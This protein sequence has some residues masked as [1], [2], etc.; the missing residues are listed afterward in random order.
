MLLRGQLHIHTTYSDGRLTPQQAANRY[1]ELGFDFIAFTDHDHL[2]KPSY[3][4]AIE[5]VRSGM[6]VFFGIELTVGTTLGYVHVSRIESP[7]Y[8]LHT[9][10]HPGDYDITLKQ[11]IACIEHVAQIYDLDAV[12]V[13]HHG[14]YTPEFD[15]DEIHYPKIA[16]DDSHTTLGCGRAWIELES[17]RERNAIMSAIRAGDYTN[18]YAKGQ[19]KAMVIA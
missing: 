1:A 19:A 15:T 4:R 18:C 2:L 9:F 17:R 16:S 11:T 14:F 6:I 5:D 7:A 12:E 13:T 10:N 3:R 8:T